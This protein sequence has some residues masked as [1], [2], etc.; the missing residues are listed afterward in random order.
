IESLISKVKIA[1]EYA[2]I[3]T[4]TAAEADAINAGET[5]LERLL[6]IREEL[7]ETIQSGNVNVRHRLELEKQLQKVLRITKQEVDEEEESQEDVIDALIRKVKIAEEY[8]NIDPS[9]IGREELASIR[10]GEAALDELF[11]IRNE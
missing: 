7:N 10:E 2:D 9:A 1:R 3:Q 5:A 8:A 4:P 6:E 11:T